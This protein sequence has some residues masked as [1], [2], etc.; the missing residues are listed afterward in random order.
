MHRST[1]PPADEAL[2]TM[3]LLALD[4]STDACSAALMLDREIIVRFEIAAQR[5]AERILPMIE[6]VLAEAGLRPSQLDAVAFGRGPGA[7][8]G[9]RIAASVTQGI[10]LGAD[11]PVVPVSSLAALAHGV[12]REQAA[13]RVIA[14]FDA[15]IG[16]VYC[17]AYACREGEARAVLAEQVAAPATLALPQAGQ[18]TGAGSAWRVYQRELRERLG[19]RLARIA[20]AEHACAEDVA[21]LAA[22]LF[23][24]GVHVGADQAVPVYLRDEVAKVKRR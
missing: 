17:G 21:A 4:T 12:W 10:A 3:R 1:G 11:L 2:D 8:T 7:F 5:Q 20:A 24:A 6:A 14:A 22:R 9:L 18:W 19:E 13:S 15:R 16:E 23:A